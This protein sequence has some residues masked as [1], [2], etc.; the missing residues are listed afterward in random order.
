VKESLWT[1]NARFR[2]VTIC[3]SQKC[4]FGVIPSYELWVFEWLRVVLAEYVS[5]KRFRAMSSRSRFFVRFFSLSLFP[6]EMRVFDFVQL[7][8][9]VNII[10]KRFG[11][12]RV[13]D[14][15]CEILLN[16]SLW[17]RNAGVRLPTPCGSRKCYFWSNPR[18]E[19][20][21]NLK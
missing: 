10:L 11:V 7:V 4:Y 18:Y 8:V 1:R 19:D 16:V 2:L 15:S 21:Y 5:L 14:I 13:I 20:E 9:G 12:L 6:P 3:R 17:S